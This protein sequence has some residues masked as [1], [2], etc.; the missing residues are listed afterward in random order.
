M[1]DD[2]EARISN[3]KN[4]QERKLIEI[5]QN[6]TK[7]FRKKL[8]RLKQEI[9]NLKKSHHDQVSEIKVGQQNELEEMNDSHQKTL[10]NSR[11]KFMKE[12]AKFEA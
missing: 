1:R 9:E 2:Y 11:L 7:P 10:E 5:R 4:D 3:L 12:K 6:K 8:P